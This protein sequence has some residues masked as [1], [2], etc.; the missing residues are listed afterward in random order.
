MVL[1]K[2]IVFRVTLVYHMCFCSHG[3]SLF[4]LNPTSGGHCLAK[5]PQPT[6]QR[7]MWSAMVT[8]NPMVLEDTMLRWNILIK[9]NF[10]LIN[11]FKK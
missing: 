5:E 9:S 1:T 10:S 8:M 7:Y 3:L 4:N 6:A 2:T 11:F